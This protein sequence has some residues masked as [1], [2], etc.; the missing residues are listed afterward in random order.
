MKLGRNSAQSCP[1]EPKL[2]QNIE[3][4]KANSEHMVPD[5]GPLILGVKIA[6]LDPNFITTWLRWTD[7]IGHPSFDDERSAN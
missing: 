6:I 1:F 7:I 5:P 2:C 3:Q 4:N